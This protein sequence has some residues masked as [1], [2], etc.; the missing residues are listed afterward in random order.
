VAAAVLLGSLPDAAI[1]EGVRRAEWPARLQRLTQGPLAASLPAGWELWLDGGHNPA[2]GEALARMAAD[3]R[4]EPLD[5]VVGMLNTKD[6]LGFLGPL[7]GVARSLRA[8]AIPGEANSLTAEQVAATAR[9][10]GL[11]ATP[12][13]TVAEAVAELA[14]LPGPARLLICGSLY[15]A[16]TVLAEN[17]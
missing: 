2:A 9:A 16:G 17:G 13:A 4:D 1:L 7:A 10:E 6:S 8:V 12:A 14:R 15:L 5:L 11:E 3:W